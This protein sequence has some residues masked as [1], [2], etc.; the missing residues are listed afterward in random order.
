MGFFSNLKKATTKTVAAAFKSTFSGSTA[1]KTTAGA[2]SNKKTAQTTQPATPSN[3]TPSPPPDPPV[4]ANNILQWGDIGFFV[5]PT[6]IRS[7]KGMSIKSSTTTETEENGDDAYVKKKK[8][9][10]YEI[11]FTAIL[12]KR[13]GEG[14]VLGAA[15]HILECCRNGYSGFVY[16]KGTKIVASRMMGTSANIQNVIV[17]PNGAWIACEIQVT[18]KQCGNLEGS[19][20]ASPS[21]DSGSSSGGG[22]GGGKGPWTATVYYSASSGA[23]MSVSA[24]SSISYSDAEKK[25]YAKVPKNAQWASTKKNQAT[26]QTAAAKGAAKSVS[27]N[28]KTASKSTPS[29]NKAI[30][31]VRDVVKA[32]TKKP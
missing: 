11:T 4:D 31:G 3:P 6:G 18:L 19:T 2:V 12:D 30:A 16:T 27:S 17:A 32:V 7:F 10:A 25:A 21:T 20:G 9:G 13:L 15:R 26:N 29:V 28:A 8:N 24:T 22:G 5:K 14:D 23:T 1:K